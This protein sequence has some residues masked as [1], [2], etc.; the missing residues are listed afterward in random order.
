MCYAYFCFYAGL[1]TEV[2]LESEDESEV[3]TS[4]SQL[5][6]LAMGDETQTFFVDSAIESIT[7]ESSKIGEQNNSPSTS[8][9][10]KQST[11]T[12]SETRLAADENST[13][14][15]LRKLREDQESQK[16]IKEWKTFISNKLNQLE[17]HSDFDIHAY[18]TKIIDSF[19]A[20]EDK[21]FRDIVGGKTPGEVSRYFLATLQLAN[22]YNVEILQ[23]SEG[24]LASDTLKLKLLSKERY[25]ESLE[26]FMAPSEETFHE[27]LARA[28]ALNPKLP[29]SS[30]P[31]QIKKQS[32]KV[33]KLSRKSSCSYAVPSTS[34][35]KVCHRSTDFV[36]R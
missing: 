31:K 3:D 23:P 7:E 19:E 28:Q 11:T 5:G 16:R 4:D 8:N 17:Q 27:R 33:M 14:D 21:K 9:S 32:P 30:T 35:A 22:T 34:Q 1:A 18:G 25:H 15:I 29:L 26:D 24:K 13:E 20:Q 10:S 2:Y 36:S 6:S 12:C